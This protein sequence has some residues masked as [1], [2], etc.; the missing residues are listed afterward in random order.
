MRRRTVVL[1]VAIVGVLG[2]CGDAN[3]TE[4]FP[5]GRFEQVEAAFPTTKE[6]NDDLTFVVWSEVG[7]V[8]PAGTYSIN[9]NLIT[10][11]TDPLCEPSGDEQ[12]TYKWAMDDTT[13]T[14]AVQ[15]DDSCLPRNEILTSELRQVEDDSSSRTA[16]AGP[17][18]AEMCPD[19]ASP[20]SAAYDLESGDF[21]WASCPPA[22]GLFLMAGASEDTVWVEETKETGAP[23]TYIALDADSGE[24][25]WRGDEARFLDAVPADADRPVETPPL[26]AGV[27][28][29]GGQQRPMTGTDA[30]DGEV[31]WTRPGHLVYDD[32]WAVSD[33][34]VFALEN[35]YDPE[36]P[37]PP[38]LVAYEVES[39]EVRW[40]RDG[41]GSPW[42][43]T[44]ER[45]LVM[46]NNLEVVATDD[47]SVLWETNYPLTESGFPRMMGGL[48]NSESVFVSFT[49]RWSGGD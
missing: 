30:V 17:V 22:G 47:G 19:G 41:F 43:V 10:F 5:T 6:F 28:L 24:E 4:V 32:V 33:D 36:D 48:A 9:G 1:A 15:G 16:E 25:L 34:A 29:D 31:F 11:E 21:R 26:V 37:Q 2:A 49:S 46:W 40:E 13:L 8:A 27:Q 39:G 44:G 3:E 12:A 42:H 7:P 20:I 18:P 38:A 23:S 45:L 35:D 14:F